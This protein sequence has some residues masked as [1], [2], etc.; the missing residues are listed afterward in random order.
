MSRFVPDK[1]WKAPKRLCGKQNR[2]V[3]VAFF[4]SEQ[5][6]SLR[7]SVCSDGVYCVV[8]ILFGS[9]EIALTTE[10]LQDWSNAKR[11]VEKHIATSDHNLSQEKS[12][13]F[14]RVTGQ[15]QQS[16]SQQLSKAECD[17]IH[18]NTKVLNALISLIVTCG[19]QNVPIRGKTDQRSNFNA[20]LQY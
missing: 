8:C 7:Y 18:K 10:P 19:R 14:L 4:D 17:M 13:G 9:Q 12:V 20:F 16:I 2:S 3:P 1:T 15:K 6:P 5:Y 11:I